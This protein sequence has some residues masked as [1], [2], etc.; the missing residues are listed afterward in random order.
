MEVGQGSNL[1]CS[2]KEKKKRMLHLIRVTPT[3]V[4][5]IYILG[6]RGIKNNNQWRGLLNTVM[7]LGVP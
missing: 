2:A 6:G 4:F 5:I 1:G 3:L 7:N